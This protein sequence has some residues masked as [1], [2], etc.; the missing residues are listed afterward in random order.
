[1]QKKAGIYS[2]SLPFSLLVSSIADTPK[3]AGARILVQPFIDRC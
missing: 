3:Q 2:R 1:M